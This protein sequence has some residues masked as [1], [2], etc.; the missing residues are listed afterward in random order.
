MTMKLHHI[1]RLSL[2]QFWMGAVSVL[3]LGTLNR[4]LRVEMSLDLALIGLTL[5]GAHYL[6]ALVSIP[7]GHRSDAHP[8]MG[9]HRLPY[10]IAGT[11]L[12]VVTIAAAPF[13][14]AFVAENPTPLR[15][16]LTFLFFFV[17]GL[18]INVGATA[19]LA[20]VTDRTHGKDRGRVV[21]IIWTVMMFGILAGAMGGAAYLED[22]SFDRLVSLFALAAGA[23]V[24][25]TLFAL[26]GVERR[27]AT[28]KASGT[29]PLRAALLILRRSRQTR[30]F[31]TFILLGLLFHFLQDV[32]LE[33][34][35]GEVL[36]LTVRETTMFN[37][38][39]MIGVIT[40]LLVGGAV[41]I[42]R[43]GKK[44]VAAAGNLIGFV[45]FAMLAAIALS[46]EPG[47]LAVSL[48]L[49]GLGT[50][51]FTVGSVSLMMDL[52][53]DGQ[54]GL[55]VGAWTLAQALARFS[56][57]VLSGSIHNL[58]VGIGGGSQVAYGTVFGI[59][60]VGILLVTWLLLHVNVLAFRREVTDLQHSME[61]S[62]G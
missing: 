32:I 9:Y 10:I 54:A 25:L 4:I 62:L 48:V 39:N 23:V 53:V 42:P 27:R 5:G 56:S 30:L 52:T 8:Y 36:N 57:S 45:A 59:Q 20:L 49:M 47:P 35:G 60:A 29:P 38:Y 21:S 50:G 19:Y 61:L 24:L 33:P 34:F 6:A 3:I 51:A 28:L 17:E 31:F 22:Y 13:A 15:L 11:A 58:I 26:W 40:G 44:R 1:L 46:R 41:A 2:Y 37:A 14:A 18:G 12:A 7:I 43:I 16:G 55:F